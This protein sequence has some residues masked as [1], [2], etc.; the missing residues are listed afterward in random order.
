MSTS[1]AQPSQPQTPGRFRV[2]QSVELASNTPYRKLGQ[3]LSA[4]RVQ[5][6]MRTDQLVCEPHTRQADVISLESG[7][8]NA[9]RIWSVLGITLARLHARAPLTRDQFILVS[10]ASALDLDEILM[11]VRQYTPQVCDG[12]VFAEVDAGVTP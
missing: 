7:D 3:L 5:R 2:R 12:A 9:R 10:K 1:H 11:T 4:F 6:K 8:C